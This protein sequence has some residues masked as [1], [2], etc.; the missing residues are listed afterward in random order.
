[1]SNPELGSRLRG[2]SHL[3]LNS[4]DMQ[5]TADFYERL[6]IP[7]IAATPI[8]FGGQHFFFD[9]GN[10]DTIAYF[11]WPDGAGEGI[12][13]RPG[14][15]GQEQR[16]GA[17]HHVAM[18]I[19]PEDVEAWAEHLKSLG[20]GFLSIVHDLDFEK[21]VMNDLSVMGKPDKWA[22]SLYFVGPDKEQLEVCAWLPALKDLESNLAGLGSADERR[23]AARDRV[24]SMA[25]QIAKAQELEKTA[26]K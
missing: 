4:S 7:L 24:T 16:D 17:M 8:A 21:D 11:Y 13:G 5:A 18:K 14:I 10:G 19:D 2:L 3:A 22:V 25:D 6:G 9:I 12:E 1:M 20:L 23:R 26:G 15:A